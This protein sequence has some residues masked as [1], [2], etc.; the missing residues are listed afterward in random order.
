MADQNTALGLVLNGS[1]ERNA[2]D[3]IHANGIAGIVYRD[4]VSGAIHIGENSLITNEVGGQQLLYAEDAGANPIDIRVTNGSNLIVDGNTTVGGD[5]SVAGTTTT[6]GIV[7]TGDITTDTLTVNGNATVGGDL[8]VTGTITQNGVAVATVDDVAAEATTR[9]AADVAL[10]A[11]I[12]AEAA[13]RAAADTTLQ[14]NINT[15][16]TNLTNAIAA[17]AAT[18]AAQDVVLTNRVVAVESR[19]SALEGRMGKAE[20]DIRSL[21]KGIAMAAALQTPAINDGDKMAVK[22]GAAT[23]DGEQGLGLGFAARV[24]DSVTV[25]VDVASGFPDTVARGGVNFSF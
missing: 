25:N 21:R 15:V 19:T 9:A 24:N 23:Y 12:D 6:N 7:N 1:F 10:Q 18:R 4:P 22:V 11:N 14:A 2:I 13:T 17:E 20:R 16:N 8:A 5:L 3:N